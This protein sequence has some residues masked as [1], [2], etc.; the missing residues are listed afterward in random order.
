MAAASRVLNQSLLAKGIEILGVRMEPA[1]AL[2]RW[3]VGIGLGRGLAERKTAA[4][5]MQDLSDDVTEGAQVLDWIQG[6]STG[7]TVG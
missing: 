5:Q 4:T 7:W 1:P 6:R 3:V 2:L